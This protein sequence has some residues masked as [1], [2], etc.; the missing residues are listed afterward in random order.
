MAKP[1]YLSD[2]LKEV[3]ICACEGKDDDDD[4]DDKNE[5]RKPVK[6]LK[7]LILPSLFNVDLARYFEESE[8][9]ATSTSD[10]AIPP[11]QTIRLTDLL[12]P[13]TTCQRIMRNKVYH[14]HPYP[15]RN[16]L[17]NALHNLV[18]CVFYVVL[19]STVIR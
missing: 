8:T 15:C 3:E 11:L 2:D 6:H 12:L 17:S 9:F 13:L 1:C 19:L 18:Y 10:H 7:P 16:V 4:E 14:H 5:A